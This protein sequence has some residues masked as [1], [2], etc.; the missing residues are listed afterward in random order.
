MNCIICR[1]AE[2]ID[3]FTSIPFERGEFRLLM[4]NVPAQ[5]C[6]NCGEALVDEDVAAAL[7]KKADDILEQGL[8]DEV[9]DY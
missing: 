3:G 8:Q 2:L 1:Q 7:L 4:R 9:R 5:V 6:H